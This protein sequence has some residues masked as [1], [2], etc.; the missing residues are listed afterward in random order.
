[1]FSFLIGTVIVL[2]VIGFMIVSPGF[3]SLVILILIAVGIGIFWLIQ[4]NKKESEQRQQQAAANEQW[5]LTSIKPSDISLTG[6]SL[7]QNGSYWQLKG[8][9]TNNSKFNLGFIR[10]LVTMQDCPDQSCKII[11]QEDTRTADSRYSSTVQ[12]TLVPAGQVRLF[13]TDSMDF[14]NLPPATKLRWDYKITQ[15]RAAD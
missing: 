11:G 9:I 5:A 3:R 10:F 4:S 8:T 7:A 15:I 1:M 6:V 12:T 2:L 14:K 13:G